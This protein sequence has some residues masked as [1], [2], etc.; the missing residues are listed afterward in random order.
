M[1]GFS[2]VTGEMLQKTII[3]SIDQEIYGEWLT[4]LRSSSS[5]IGQAGVVWTVAC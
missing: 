3:S 4:Y 2:E 5:S 1:T